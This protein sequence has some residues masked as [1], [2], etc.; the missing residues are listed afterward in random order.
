M[1]SRPRLLAAIAVLASLLALGAA[2]Y[3]IRPPARARDLSPVAV[4]SAPVAPAATQPAVRKYTVQNGDTLGGIAQ[5]FGVSADALVQANAL[6]NP[7]ALA[8]G[9][10]LSIPSA[11]PTAAAEGTAG[12]TPD[13]PSLLA[14]LPARAADP[15]PDSP[16]RGTTW[17]TYY[18][19]PNVPVMGILGEY[20]LDDLIP[21]LRAQ[22]KAYDDANG[23][24]LTVT[25]AL[26]LIYGMATTLPGANADHLTYLDDAVVREYIDRA[27]WEGMGVILDVQIGAVTPLQAIKPAFPYLKY[28]NVHLAL[29]P[30]F[31]M[32]TP[33]Q[34]VP[35]EPP[36]AITADQINEVQA[37]MTAS[38]QE[39]GAPAH[40]MLIV[41]QFLPYMIVNKAAIAVEPDID[42]VI[43]ADGY[44]PP[45]PK[46]SKYNLFMADNVQF[47]GFKLFYRWDDP[48]LNEAQALGEAPFDS[49][50]SIDITPSLIVYQ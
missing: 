46:I 37:A 25:P 10:R 3:L 11:D 22:A 8:I 20:S 40:K 16:L 1:K 12:P 30:E 34:T 15:A 26:H 43:C 17:V 27:A 36:G 42:V 6:A 24:N 47:A 44:G 45:V 28:R 31:A 35:G 33:G 32:T 2:L 19:R 48:L 21:R 14:R 39:A 23:P 9:Q 7:D 13:R 29:D 41:H 18:G 5:R 49:A 38:M 50:G 4:A